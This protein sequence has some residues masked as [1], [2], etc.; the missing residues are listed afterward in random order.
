M[1]FVNRLSWCIVLHES[2]QID[3]KQPQL[4]RTA[5]RDHTSEYASELLHLIFL[6]R[7]YCI[8]KKNVS[9]GVNSTRRLLF[10]S[11]S[12][13]LQF[14]SQFLCFSGCCHE[15]EICLDVCLCVLALVFFVCIW[16]W[17]EGAGRIGQRGAGWCQLASGHMVQSHRIA[18]TDR[19]WLDSDT[20][21]LS[22]LSLP[23]IPPSFLNNISLFVCLLHVYMWICVLVMLWNQCITHFLKLPDQ[24]LLV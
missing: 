23:P 22:L 20:L 2:G 5:S 19:F 1:F 21:A 11:H 13:L 12:S 7:C 15:H 17:H 4:F 6:L 24:L 9:I 8:V 14:I 18:I 3:D 10:V 16:P